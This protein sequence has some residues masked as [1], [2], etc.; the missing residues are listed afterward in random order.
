M[1]SKYKAGLYLRLSRDDGEKD[2]ESQSISNQR[3]FTTKYANDNGYEV[4]ESYIDDG[5][6]GT[7]FDRP[8]FNR[9]IADIETGKINMVITKDL[10]RL[11]RDYITT[12]HYLERYFP[13][14][15]I[16]YIA[17]NDGLDTSVDSTNN[18]MG[19]FRSVM[20]DM[21]AKDI[22][23]KVRTA[24]NTRKQ[25]GKF[26]G[27]FAPFGY[28]K[29][30]N[31]KSRLIIDPETAPYVKQ[32][33]SLYI[34]G[35]AQIAI[36][37]KL[38]SDGVPTPSQSKNLTH[39][40][41]RFKGVWNEVIVKRILTNQTYIGNITQNRSKKVSYKVNKRLILPPEEWIVINDVHEGIISDEDFQTVQK[42]ISKKIYSSA[43]RKTNITHTLSGL[44]FCADCGSP[45]SFV[46]ESETRT[47]LVCST[48]R[49]HA[50]LKLCTS[51]CI[52]EDYVENQ[53]KLILKELANQYVDKDELIHEC[54]QTQNQNNMN[55]L[56]KQ[57]ESKLADS[58]Q[59]LLSLYKDKVKKIVSES[60][61]ID[62]S[63]SVKTEQEHFEKQIG[64]IKGTINK[65][66]DFD[67]IRDNLSG[68]L[69]FDKLD[70]NILVMLINK[71]HIHKDKQITIEF[72]FS[73]PE[74]DG[75][76]K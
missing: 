46:R 14:N 24:L 49:R 8:S 19:P 71:I 43:N 9:M 48:W 33:Y 36:A 37:N 28:M 52:R 6:S 21:Y 7:N 59:T 66:N 3:D 62:M 32:I 40:Q 56:L 30:P 58:K 10:S 70:R 67:S 25:N 34:Q 68:F 61:Y 27:S 57:L 47:Y 11:G 39:T 53:V 41:T 51:H 13:Q 31:D 16:R 18:D 75:I 38:T 23:K 50:K 72:A 35:N 55:Q 74:D 44:I 73:N 65:Q 54:I 29:D 15:N 5:F 64:E 4:I 42:M 12:G 22:S 76:S 17:I 20:N 26:I 60:D 69:K 63:T 45:M 2:A 1:D